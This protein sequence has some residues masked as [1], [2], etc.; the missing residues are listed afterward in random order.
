[1]E[2]RRSVFASGEEAVGDGLRQNRVPAR[3]A[4]D[5]THRLRDQVPVLADLLAGELRMK[6]LP[7]LRQALCPISAR[8]CIDCSV[9]A[10]WL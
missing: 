4:G 8:H 1:M 10:V 3:D 2:A 5:A 6:L 7:S 9:T